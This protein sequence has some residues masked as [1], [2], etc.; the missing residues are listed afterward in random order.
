MHIELEPS[1]YRLRS[2]VQESTS[3]IVYRAEREGDHRPVVLKML[4]RE[5]AT[6]SALA[7]YRH[8]LEVLECLRIP[9]VVQVLALEMVQGLSMLVLEDFGAESLARLHREQRFGLDSVLD[10]AARLADALGEIHD[11]GFV[12]CDVNPANVLLNQETGE[13]KLADFGASFRVAGEPTVP[14]STVAPMGTL[15]YMAPEQTGRMNRPVDYRADLYSLGV[16]IY[17]LCTGRLPFDTDDPL[18]LVHS[19]IAR[20][21]I[22]IH[23]LDP[24][25]PEAISDIVTRLM[26][27]MLE[28][29]YQSA[30][31]C[32]HDL[33]VCQGQLRSH[34]HVQRFVLGERD[35]ERFRIPSRLYGREHELRA[36]RSAAERVMA[37]ARELVLVAGQP[38][39]GKSALVRE[40]AAPGARGRAYFID[41]KFD[42]YQR[43]VPY[44]ALASAFGALMGQFLTEPEERVAHW[45]RALRAALGSN[46]QV[47]VEAIPD[48]TFLIGP[49]PPVARLG[50]AEAEQRFNVVFQGFL[51]V[52]CSAEHPLLLF[53]DDLQWADTATLRLMKQMM[54]D[55]GVHHL[56]IIGAYRDDEVDGAHL[57]TLALG[58]LRAGDAAVTRVTLGPLGIEDVRQVLAAA[59]Q[60]SPDDCTELAELVLAKT[61][62]N[63]FFVDQFLR[64]LYQDRLLRFDRVLRG[65]RWELSAIRAL[66][67]TDNVVDLMIERIRKLPAATQRVLDFAACT[68]SVFD[69][70]TLAIICEDDPV[71]IHGHL[72]PA[73]ELGLV[74]PLSAPDARPT[75]TGSAP[76]AAAGFHA[77]AHDRVQQAAYGLVSSQE[78]SRVHLRIARLLEHALGPEQREQRL[79]ELAEHFV[80]GAGLLD[81]P[82]ERQRVARL[83]LTAGKRAQEAMARDS[84]LR[85][86]LAGLALVP[87]PRW[88]EHYELTRDLAL[89][90][91]ETAYLTDHVDAAEALCEEILASARDVFDEVAVRE[92]QIISHVMRRRL[93]EAMA[94][95][96]DTLSMLGVEVP[97]APEQV[98]GRVPEL[99]GQLRLDEAGVAALE[100]LPRLT[101]PRAAMILRVLERTGSAAFYLDPPLRTL[102]LLTQVALCMRHGHSSQSAIVYAHYAAMLCG[103][104]PDLADRLGALALRLADHFPDPAVEVRT[105]C[106]FYSWV[107]P[108]SHPMRE[109][110]EPFRALVQSGLQLGEMEFAA[111]GAAWYPWYRFYLGDSLDV[112]HHEI[113][114]FVALARRHDMVMALAG[115]ATW[116]PVI[117]ELLGQPATD[118]PL[119]LDWPLLIALKYSALAMGRYILG[120]HDAAFEAAERSQEHAASA[121]GLPSTIEQSYWYS[122]AVLA[123]LGSRADLAG[124]PERSGAL[125]AQVEG[126]QVIMGAWATR[127]PENV[128]ARHALIEAERARVRNAPHT[129]VM[130]LYDDAIEA[131][132]AHGYV[133]EEAVACE[134]AAGFYAGLGRVK[135][136]HVYL[137]DAYHAYRRWGAQ[138][139]VARLEE[140]HPWLVRRRSRVAESQSASTPS[141]SGTSQMLDVES[142]VRASQAISSHLVL[143]ELLAEL[144]K[145]IVATAGAE[146]GYLL[147][148]RGGELAIEAGGHAG[149]GLYRALPSLELSQ[150]R[151]AL[152]LAAVGY[153]AR[154]G[155]SL[156][157]R[158][159]AE[160]EPYAGDPYV[161]AHRPR[162]LL[163][164]PIARPGALVGVIYL[165]NNLTVDAFTP[166]RVEIVQ[167][168]ASQAAISIENA[169]LLE[170]LRLSKEEAERAREEAERAREEAERAREEAERAS[171]AKSE[172]LASVNHELRTP[173]NG[174]IGMIEL[175][176]GT[177]LDDEQGDFLATA[178]TS[179]EQLMRIIRDTLDLSRIEAG[180][181]DLEPIRFA[182]IECLATLERML[183][184]RVLAQG[185]TFT[186][187]LD[188]DIPGHLV[189]DRD[190]LL[191]IL[192]NLLGNAIKFTPSGGAVSV[193]VRNLDRS[194]EHVLLGF[195]VRDTGVGIAAAEQAQIFQPFTQVRAPGAPAGGSGLGLAIAS[196]LVALM[197]G[198][199]TVES[200]P[201]KGSCFSFT[202]RFG[203]WQPEQP[204]QPAQP[205]L[206]ATAAAAAAAPT[207]GPVPARGLR[208]LVV[209]DNAVNQLV[210]VR[211]LGMDGHA[212]AV[213]E[214]GAEA[215]RMLEREPFDVVLMDVYMPVMDGR[216]ATREIRRGEQGTGRH[217]PI[218]AVTASATTEVVQACATAGMDHF[219]SKPLRRDTLGSCYGASRLRRK[220]RQLELAVRGP[221]DVRV[222]VVRVAIQDEI[223]VVIDVDAGR[224]ADGA[225]AAGP[226]VEVARGH[227]RQRDRR[228]ARRGAEQVGVV[229]PA[230]EGP[231]K[232]ALLVATM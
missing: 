194:D 186:R 122:L 136:A 220:L 61:E 179:A 2:V 110:A 152:A 18:E 78:R 52:V 213:A 32:A 94:I 145:I 45:R 137:E 68:G 121:T 42:Q 168:L 108:W 191:Q 132:R 84:S 46:G 197:G 17:E 189:G 19:H 116:E 75:D 4:R 139:K 73:I 106:V 146:R 30:R 48:L 39:T 99:L 98:A 96:L 36:L 225:I 215:L 21:P 117:R 100:D 53:L 154:T 55:P 93:P 222:G 171:R 178:K 71:A 176:L 3:T 141:S 219:L 198:T 230:I 67:I 86:L 228:G 41:G 190:R 6:P 26:A 101:D 104:E 205:L 102:L 221:E 181:L 182:L 35:S 200:E 185:L 22:S 5:A 33:R 119:L 88:Q 72:L 87:A 80:L 160:E 50:P 47:L 51:E 211:L 169:R 44:S 201:G 175:L 226:F 138:A 161:R 1:G 174:I 172:F 11:R 65:W 90:T 165:E 192:I 70:G 158:D 40:L 170:N 204:E 24:G 103:A 28:D 124:D 162:S 58:Q 76:V 195:G 223:A 148:A 149:S 8:E 115:L 188:D 7:R 89:A 164:A 166:T 109:A 10:I 134:R 120:D 210:A 77:F 25:I 60:R 66:R 229:L 151:D 113:S 157:L 143:G 203:L 153:V 123:A 135:V 187:E 173:M 177:D 209:E 56:L 9:G 16:T 37:G 180:R 131:A 59:L 92:L 31:G 38:G 63:P 85:F 14:G 167:M 184:A 107:H 114:V 156:V 49:Q 91:V 155:K 183:A 112:V 207:A 227:A 81:D 217:V 214:N 129:E 64:T 144:M 218:I 128:A 202:A 232:S 224:R 79:F 231:E 54:T 199:I 29:R 118:A 83:C 133:R 111:Y 125:L 15:A 57:L 69:A 43:N 95:G 142:V 212:C 62:G 23:E 208:G 20:H 140:Q 82:S 150:H 163:C 216:A 13:L 105:K 206:A 126:K 27:K 127:V 159:A 34:G 12:H 196:R 97:R 130:A 147:L 193:R 74:L